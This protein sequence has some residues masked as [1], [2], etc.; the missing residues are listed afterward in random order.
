[1]GIRSPLV[2][3]EWYHCYNRG[4]E[5]RR[6]F[7]SVK[8][9][10]RFLLLMY[11]GNSSNSI[12]ISNLKDKNLLGLLSNPSIDPVEPLVEIGA[13][14]LMPN[15]FHFLLKETCEGGTA[16]F[17]QKVFTGYTMYFNKKND[18]T[19]ALFSGVFKS[20]HVVDDRY[21][22]WLVSY[23]HLNP[24]ELVEPRWKEGVGDIKKIHKYLSKYRYSSLPD[25]HNS[26][27]LEKKLL[28]NSIF[29]LFAE[30]PPIKEMLKESREY[31]QYFI[32]AKP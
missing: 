12:H 26:R 6:V 10:E 20:K 2:V 28:G 15:H 21:L 18:R 22:K 3:G 32:K 23:I 16:A 27:R 14:S 11:V 1:M 19:G 17:M 9:Y 31:H 25:F 13:Y 8:D 30:I 7:E 4:V 5:K 24:I 29:E